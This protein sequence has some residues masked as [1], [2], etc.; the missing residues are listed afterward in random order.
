MKR[1]LFK[2][3]GITYHKDAV[4]E[5]QIENDDY[6]M[7]AKQ[8]L[9]EYG[10]D[11]R[12]YKYD[13]DIAKVELV[14]EP[15]NEYDRNAVAVVIDGAKVGYI[16]KGSASRVKN[17]LA[18]PDF[19]HIETEIGGGPYKVVTE[20]GELDKG[21]APVWIHLT[22]CTREEQDDRIRAI[23]QAQKEHEK[24]VTESM[25]SAPPVPGPA[26]LPTKKKGSAFFT[27]CGVV[28]IVLGLL[29]ALAV[30]PAGA[31]S[32]LLGVFS[33]MYGKKR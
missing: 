26:R 1:E 24:R 3:T 2:V 13:Y 16:K 32:V 12:I 7:T 14:P 20:D 33:I 5:L 4:K 19:D 8:I 11:E 25:E 28:L 18:S 31:V 30:L 22:I 23:E 15:D 17:L 6:D 27:V 29:L 10:E 21:E 9:G